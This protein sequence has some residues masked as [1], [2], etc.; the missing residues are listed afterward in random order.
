MPSANASLVQFP[1]PLSMPLALHPVTVSTNP[2]NALMTT[3]CM[4]SKVLGGGGGGGGMYA[5]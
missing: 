5:K 4:P 2:H 3:H 1:F